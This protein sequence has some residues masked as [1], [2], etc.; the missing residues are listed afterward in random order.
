M[1]AKD[2]WPYGKILR[3]NV[4]PAERELWKYL[5]KRQFGAVCCR[6]VPVCDAYIADF[7]FRRAKLVIEVDGG[8]HTIPEQREKDRRR[9]IVMYREGYQV[10][11]VTNKEVFHQ[12]PVVL[13]RIANAVRQNGK[14]PLWHKH[15]S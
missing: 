10:V 14:I 9:D 13:A 3:K 7:A 8:Y 6:Q 2:L 5:R 1:T 12:L 15:C 11:R 4:T